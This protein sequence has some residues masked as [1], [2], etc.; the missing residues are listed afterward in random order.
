MNVGDVVW[1]TIPQY[2]DH[3]IIMKDYLGVVVNEHF[4]E[5]F[6]LMIRILHFDYRTGFMGY[7]H[8]YPAKEHEVRLVEDE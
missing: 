2:G 4:R 8:D 3:E 6:P 5:D 1:V 7:H